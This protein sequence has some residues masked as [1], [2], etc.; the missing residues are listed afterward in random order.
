MGLTPVLWLPNWPL[1]C[2]DMDV[3]TNA[4]FAR[5]KT[6]SADLS[7][8]LDPGLSPADS[9]RMYADALQA[10]ADRLARQISLIRATADV[11]LTPEQEQVKKDT[12]FVMG[13]L[14]AL[15]HIQQ[16]AEICRK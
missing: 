12:G 15:R 7:I 13:H 8:L 2:S 6:D 11:L 9:L 10:Q 5:I 14:Q 1:T 4:R 3:T 16:R